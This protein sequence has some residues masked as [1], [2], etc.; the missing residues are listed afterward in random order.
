MAKD[1][2]YFVTYKIET[3]Y[4]IKELEEVIDKLFDIPASQYEDCEYFEYRKKLITKA[5]L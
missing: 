2:T 3:N 5:R 4:D 1:K